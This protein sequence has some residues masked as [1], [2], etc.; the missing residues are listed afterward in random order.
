MV[1]IKR[2]STPHQPILLPVHNMHQLLHQMLTHDN[3]DYLHPEKE[4]N[5]LFNGPI[6]PATNLESSGTFRVSLNS[7]TASL[8]HFAAATFIS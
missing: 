6:A 4:I 5:V 8:A 3:R 2:R 7:L 1:S